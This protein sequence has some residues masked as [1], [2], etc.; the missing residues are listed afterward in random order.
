[1]GLSPLAL[2]ALVWGSAVVTLAAGRYDA[3]GDAVAVLATFGLIFPALGW[4]TTLGAAAPPIPVRR[5][6]LELSLVL[7]YL[8]A[9]AVLFTGFGLSAFHAALPAGRTEAA[10]LVALKL[11]VHV[12][13][14]ALLLGLAGASLRPLIA[15]RARSRA[16]W[17][18]LAVLGAA[19]LALM[20]VISPSL[21]NITALH[22]APPMLAL[23]GAGAFAWIAVEA[24]LCEEFLFRAVLQ[25]R[26]AA[27][28]RSEIGAVVI[29]ALLFGLAH[30]PGL[31][32]RGHADE[33]GHSQSLIQVIAYAV[34]V[35]SPAGVFVG[36]MWSR[37]K[38]LLLVV[39]LHALIDVLPFIPEFARTW[40]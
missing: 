8:A 5:P 27:A 7:A 20:C 16:F 17:L 12:A 13:L 40:M 4:L 29:G 14:P 32:L 33:A 2:Y 6:A 19:I 10:L 11:V 28:M 1:V 15:V 3:A 9:Y 30:V 25:S 18:S 24:G 39:L 34:A 21:K 31:F 35:L 26:L 37:T 36:F 38:S 22:L 23:A